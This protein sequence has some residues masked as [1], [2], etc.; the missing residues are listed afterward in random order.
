MLFAQRTR[1]DDAGREVVFSILRQVMV[2]TVSNLLALVDSVAVLPAHDG[3]FELRLGGESLA[4]S[5]Q[6]QFVE[7]EEA[8]SD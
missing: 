6:E 4:G 8:G 3:T 2:D 1:L 7:A 5:L